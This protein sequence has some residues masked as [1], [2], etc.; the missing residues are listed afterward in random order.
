MKRAYRIIGGGAAVIAG[1]L[2][3]T[4][5]TAA[6]GEGG[7]ATGPVTIVDPKLKAWHQATPENP[8]SPPKPDVDYGI[9]PAT[10]AFRHPVAAPLTTNAPNFT[11]QLDHWDQNSYAKNV[12]VIGFY[13]HVTSPWHAWASVVDMDGKRYLYAHDRDYMRVLDITDPRMAEVYVPGRRV[14]RQGSCENWDASAVTDYFG[15]IT[16]AWNKK[17]KSNVLVASYEIGRLGLMDDKLRQPDKVEAQRHYNSLKGFKVFVMNGPTPDKWDL[18]ATRTTDTQHPDALI[19]QQQ[20]SG[21]LDAATWWGGKYMLLSAAPDDS[22]SL[23]E[24]PDY[25]YSPGYQVWDMADPANPKFVSQISVPGQR[26]GDND[27]VAAYL[28]N[29]RAGNRTCWMGSRIPI[30]L[31]KPIEARRQDRFW[32]HGR[33]G[34]LHL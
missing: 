25:L 22:Y 19:G 29:P 2:Y 32:R 17:L 27:S 8:P 6:S 12:E 9:D 7:H 20:G 28:D 11:G 21:S 34:L 5:L 13:P 23:T 10:G 31:T 15:G 1:L 24:Y 30:V 4:A 14:E 3:A 16:I 18:I 33:A 26:L